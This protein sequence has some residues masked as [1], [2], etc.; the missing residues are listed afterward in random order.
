M[1]EWLLYVCCVG[2]AAIAGFMY[3]QLKETWDVAEAVSH[4]QSSSVKLFE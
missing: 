3:H 4:R 2:A 1:S